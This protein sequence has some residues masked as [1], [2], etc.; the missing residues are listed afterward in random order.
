VHEPGWPSHANVSFSAS[1]AVAVHSDFQMGFVRADV[2]L[3]IQLQQ[4]MAQAGKTN[5]AAGY[6][7]LLR[8]LT[9]PERFPALT[10]VLDSGTF[11]ETEVPDEDFSFGLERILDGLEQLIRTRN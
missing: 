10:T 5:P 7:Q 11:E 4:G 9:D 6:S 3:T 2:M 1:A 8:Q